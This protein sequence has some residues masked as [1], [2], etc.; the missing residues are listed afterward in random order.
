[1]AIFNSYVKL[2]E[3]SSNNSY[4]P[5]SN[6]QSAVISRLISSSKW[7]AHCHCLGAGI[8]PAVIRFQMEMVGEDVWKIIPEIWVYGCFLSETHFPHFPH[9]IKKINDFNLFWGVTTLRL[10]NPL[11]FH[12]SA[13]VRSRLFLITLRWIIFLNPAQIIFP[14]FWC[15]F[16]CDVPG[17]VMTNSSPWLFDGPNRNRWFTVLNS[18]GGFSMANC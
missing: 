8:I 7:M 13:T 2:P 10:L 4:E 16:C 14:H 1:M 3:G 12:P 15:L 9:V 5:F 17:L 6:I 18:M 11:G